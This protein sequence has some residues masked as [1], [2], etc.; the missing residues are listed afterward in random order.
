MSQRSRQYVRDPRY[1]T[2]RRYRKQ[3]ARFFAALA[4]L[5]ISA[6]LIIAAFRFLPGLMPGQPDQTTTTMSGTIP[7]NTDTT[8]APAATPTPAPLPPHVNPLLLPLAEF[9]VRKAGPPAAGLSPAELGLT[10]NLFDG[11]GSPVAEFSRS[12][13]IS[14]LAPALYNQIPGVLTFRGNNFRNAPAFGLTNLKDKK[15]EQIWTSPVGSLPSSSWSFSWTG[16]GW[17]GQPLLVQWDEDVR[18][19]M[20]IREDKKN[21]KNLI[22]VIYATMDGNVYFYDIDDGVQTRPPI[23]IGAPVKGTPGIDP[24][25]YPVLYVG[26]GDRNSNVTGI[27][28]RIYNLID[29]SLLLYKET[30]DN[31]ANRKNW[32]ASDSSPIF[33]AA[34]DTL[35]FP[36]ENG[37]IYTAR[38]NTHFNRETGELSIDPVFHSYRYNM[39]GLNL[40]GIESSMAV[41]DGYGFYSDNSGFINCLDLNSLKPVWSRNL[42]DD[43]DVTPVL[44]LEGD[45]AVLYIATEVDWQKD[46]I[47]DYKGT[48]FVYKLDAMTGE[49]IWEAYYDCWTRNAANFGEDING[50]AMGT[51]VVGKLNLDGLVIFSLSMTNGV[52]SG[53]SV[54]A[55]NANDGTIAWEYKMPAYSWSSPVDVYDE[56]GHGYIVIPDSSGKLHLI[57]G[58]RGTALDVIQLTKADGTTSAGNVES[59]A[60]VFGNK[61]VIGTRGNV[62]IGVRL[63]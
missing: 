40:H 42:G 17:T 34:S 3:P 56:A 44:D 58:A 41:Y 35:I 24:R 31:N 32:G 53:N 22:E 2:G 12:N 14:L 50:G 21:K 43:S 61:L 62:I 1:R 57:D 46:I 20:N 10:S 29:Q 52:F 49:V 28:F 13:R 27:G 37:L 48:S 7:A 30:T 26:Q 38:M 23:R 11:S 39:P 8:S 33:D 16:T 25:G 36:N 55:Y 19:L 54:V 4:L 45:R 15:L 59:S 6:T 63:K 18:R 51:P 5:L 9:I 60:A 47:G